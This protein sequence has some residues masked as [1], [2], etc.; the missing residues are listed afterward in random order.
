M[1]VHGD[2]PSKLDPA[3]FRRFLVDSPLEAVGPDKVGAIWGPGPPLSAMLLA[4]ENRAQSGI[5]KPLQ[6]A[7]PGLRGLRCL[8]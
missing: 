6:N 4:P 3:A 2:P 5:Q 7:P 8:A 1:A